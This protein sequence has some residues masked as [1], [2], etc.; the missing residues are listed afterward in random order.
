MNYEISQEPFM[1]SDYSLYAFL[2]YLCVIYA[3][4]ILSSSAESHKCLVEW[5]NYKA[6]QDTVK[7]AVKLSTA[8]SAVTNKHFDKIR[9]RSTCTKFVARTGFCFVST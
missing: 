9:L 1:C 6:D 5:A 4:S 8:F 3:P 7:G 2:I